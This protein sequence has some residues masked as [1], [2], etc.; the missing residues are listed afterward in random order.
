MKPI[1]GM[2]LVW[3]WSWHFSSSYFFSRFVSVII[4]PQ[5]QKKK[6]SMEL[7]VRLRQL[8]IFF[9]LF[10]TVLEHASCSRILRIAKPDR[11]D[12]A[13]SARWLV[14]QNIW[15]VLRYLTLS[16]LFSPEYDSWASLSIGLLVDWSGSLSVINYKL[17]GAYYYGKF[18]AFLAECC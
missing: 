1:L 13:A 11:H 6:R 18:V 7:Q 8:I 15:G 14:S 2:S 9:F 12:I 16:K 4:H 5:T 17:F 10:L 3:S